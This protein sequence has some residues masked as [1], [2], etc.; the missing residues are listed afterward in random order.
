MG[1][2]GVETGAQDAEGLPVFKY[3]KAPPPLVYE[4][5]LWKLRGGFTLRHLTVICWKF[6]KRHLQ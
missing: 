3:L 6:A 5:T 4:V 2:T 1:E